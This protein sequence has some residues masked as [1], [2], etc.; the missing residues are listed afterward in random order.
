MPA[1]YDKLPLADDAEKREDEDEDEEFGLREGEGEGEGEEAE[2]EEEPGFFD[3]LHNLSPDA[4][5]LILTKSLRMYAFGYLAVMLAIYLKE[6]GFSPSTIGLLFSLTL[7]GDVLI[8]LLLTTHADRWGRKRTLQC[9]ALLALTTSVTFALSSS[10]P[11]LLLAAIFGVISPSGNE[12]G[13][14]Q[15]R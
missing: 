15:V 1:Q 10:F 13:P 9:G 14:F 12:I 7:T 8:S 3:A 2:A 6:L 11:V 5:L 4:K